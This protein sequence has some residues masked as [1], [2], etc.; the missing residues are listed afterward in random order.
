MSA[1]DATWWDVVHV[2]A[3]LLGFGVGLW[4]G[5]WIAREHGPEYG[6][7]YI[8]LLTFAADRGRA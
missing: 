5:L 3:R 4:L 2:L 7:A 6:A 8:I 1:R